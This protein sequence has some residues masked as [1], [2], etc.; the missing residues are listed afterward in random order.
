MPEIAFDQG[1]HQRGQCS[2][3]RIVS[4]FGGSNPVGASRYARSFQTGRLINGYILFFDENGT[5]YLVIY[6]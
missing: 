5:I 1:I 4:L 3:N 2:L 6:F